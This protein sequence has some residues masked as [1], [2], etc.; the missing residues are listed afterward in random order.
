LEKRDEYLAIGVAEYWV[1]DRFRR[2]M[3]VY[4]SEQ[5]EIQVGEKELYRSPLLPGFELSLA[6]ILAVADR[7]EKQS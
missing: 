3:T 5:P 4:R 1:I 7:W 2:Q 6:H